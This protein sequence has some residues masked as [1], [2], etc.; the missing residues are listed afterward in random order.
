MTCKIL[1]SYGVYPAVQAK[2]WRKKISLFSVSRPGLQHKI[3]DYLQ[4]RLPILD[5][6]LQWLV[7]HNTCLHCAVAYAFQVH[8]L[9]LPL[10]QLCDLKQ[11]VQ[12]LCAL[13]FFICKIGIITVL[14]YTVVQG[15]D[16]LISVCGHNNCYL[17]IYLI[18]L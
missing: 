6:S 9:L 7:T 11:V 5:N 3:I 2:K 14:L 15:L 17:G 8:I 16:E 18:Y 1:G 13:F 12:P 4:I 10:A